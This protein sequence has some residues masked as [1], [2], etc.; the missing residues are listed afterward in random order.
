M[1]KILITGA[2]GFIGRNLTSWLDAD[3]NFHYSI[4]TRNDDI[5]SLE[6][7]LKDVDFVIHLAAI[8]RSSD[9]VEYL[10]TN[11]L[12]TQR[13]CKGIAEIFHRDG[14]KIPIIYT[15]SIQ[16]GNGTVYGNSKFNSEIFVLE[17]ERNY[18]IPIYIMRLPNVFGKW[19]KPNYNS[20]IATFCFNIIN[21]IPITI[22]DPLVKLNLIYIDDVISRIISIVKTINDYTNESCLN[23]LPI[24]DISVGYIAELI[25]QFKTGRHNL[26]IGEV[27]NGFIRALYSTYVSYLN[28]N[29]F[30]YKIDCHNDERGSFVEMAKTANSGQFS[31]FIAY[32]GVTRGGHYHNTKTE[33]FLVIQ[34]RAR[35]RFKNIESGFQHE[36]YID[37]NKPEIVDTS[38][39][40]A[41]DIT[42]IGDDNLIVMLW[43]N[44]IFDPKNPDTFFVKM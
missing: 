34:G 41:H 30:S 14:K 13:I 27:G 8:N 26:A 16:A 36:I 29:Q 43:A 7:K 24:Y 2:K 11:I 40:W 21:D 32:P 10:N 17:L 44:E 22:N 39:G 1:K 23:N 12:L 4:F 5:D 42:N 25:H 35:F 28:C 9:E 15:S 3:S 18:N 38:P 37:G 31:Y 19:C 33:K 6:L 20:V